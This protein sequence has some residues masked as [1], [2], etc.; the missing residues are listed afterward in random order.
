MAISLSRDEPT[1]GTFM[2][3]VLSYSNSSSRWA[4]I[5]GDSIEIVEKHHSMIFKVTIDTFQDDL[6]RIM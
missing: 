5:D 3:A 4:F 2:D 1:N 6:S